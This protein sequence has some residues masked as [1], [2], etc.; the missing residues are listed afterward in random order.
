MPCS[1]KSPR[2]PTNCTSS[3][4]KPTSIIPSRN[5]PDFCRGVPA[6]TGPASLETVSKSTGGVCRYS[7]AGNMILVTPILTF[8]HQ[9]GRDP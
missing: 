6:M 2:A 1:G 9:G 3:L 4:R 5:R 7:D 8:P